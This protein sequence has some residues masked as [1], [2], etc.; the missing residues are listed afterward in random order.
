M[1]EWGAGAPERE[2]GNGQCDQKGTAPPKWERG[3]GQ[4]DRMRCWSA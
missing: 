1:T 3:N 2:R 4:C